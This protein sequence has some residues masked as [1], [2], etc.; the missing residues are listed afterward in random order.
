MTCSSSTRAFSGWSAR[1]QRIEGETGVNLGGEVLARGGA[2]PGT[3]VPDVE[4]GSP[5][6]VP[7]LVLVLRVQGHLQDIEPGSAGAGQLVK[8]E[9]PSLLHG[10]ERGLVA[11]PGQQV[12]AR[13]LA[14]EG[15]GAAGR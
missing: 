12:I 7:G 8:A 6:N 13:L 11:E 1:E 14:Q 10:P 2:G 5:A 3:G 9:G 4:I 15:R